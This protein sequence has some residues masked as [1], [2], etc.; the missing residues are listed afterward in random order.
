MPRLTTSEV[1]MM[2]IEE[3]SGQGRQRCGGN[4]CQNDVAGVGDVGLDVRRDGRL[5]QHCLGL[6]S[7][8]CQLC[9][10]GGNVSSAAVCCSKANAKVEAGVCQWAAVNSCRTGNGFSEGDCFQGN[11][12]GLR[13]QLAHHPPTTHLARVCRHP[14]CKGCAL[15]F[16]SDL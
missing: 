5:R 6:L 7:H 10:C 8:R 13:V 1:R 3:P 2:V 11:R 12:C 9:A 15:C 14:I 4:R 16:K